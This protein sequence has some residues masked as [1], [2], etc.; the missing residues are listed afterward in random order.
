METQRKEI[1]N[2]REQFQYE[3]HVLG[4]KIRELEMEKKS[5]QDQTRRS[6]SEEGLAQE[7]SHRPELVEKTVEKEINSSSRDQ[8][9]N[10]SQRPPVKPTEQRNYATVAADKLAQTPAQP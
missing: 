7:P 4:E 8:V 5:T 10:S 2:Q 3:I 9:T 6:K 1:D